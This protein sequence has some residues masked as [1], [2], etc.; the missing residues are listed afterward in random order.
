[1]LSI[2]P[3]DAMKEMLRRTDADKYGKAEAS[4]AMG[5]LAKALETPLRKGIMPGNIINGIY[6][7]IRFEYGVSVEFPLDFIA[8][9]TEKD[10]VAYT[11]PNQ[12]R[13]PERQVEGDYDD[14]LDDD[15]DERQTHRKAG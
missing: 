9:G 10:Y 3:N 7:Q 1:M 5:E 14:T 12:G 15:Y 11:I 8:P 13:L 2:E 6:E 4:A